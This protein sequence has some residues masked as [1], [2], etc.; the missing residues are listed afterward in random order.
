MLLLIQGSRLAAL[1]V[2]VRH[3]AHTFITNSRNSFLQANY[4]A[5]GTPEREAIGK[6]LLENGELFEVCRSFVFEEFLVAV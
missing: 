2:T 6:Q 4:P 3:S 5:E 1:T